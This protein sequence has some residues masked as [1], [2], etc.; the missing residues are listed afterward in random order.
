MKHLKLTFAFLLVLLISSYPVLAQDVSGVRLFQSYFF[1]APIAKTMYVEPGLDYSTTSHGD[2]S[3]S[4]LLIGA[5]GGYPINEQIEVG[6][7]LGFLNM[8]TEVGDNDESE[9]GLT[10]LGV[11]G[12]Y[13]ITSNEQLSFSAGGLITLP[14][15]E[16]KIGQSNLNFGGFGAV[17]YALEGGIVLTG[18]VG[19][20]FYEVTTTTVEY[21]QTGPNPWDV[22]A[23]EK[24]ESDRENYLQLGVGGIYPV[25]EQLNAV[26]ELVMKTDMDYMML[27]AGADYLVGNGRVRGALGLGLD[28]GAPDFQIMLGYGL[29]F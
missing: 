4:S 5:K 22:E 23:V 7:S 21:E 15:G 2:V 26:G 1:D 29:S 25:N 11:Y 12:R 27:S 19:L 18:N 28:D 17:R 10:D 6:A 14:I 20:V 3:F 9:S 24:T 8:S 13:N 16:E